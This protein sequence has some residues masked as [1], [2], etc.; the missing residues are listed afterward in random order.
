SK[1]TLEIKAQTETLKVTKRSNTFY[2]PRAYL[3]FRLRYENLFYGRVY[4]DISPRDWY[5]FDL[6]VGLTPTK[7]MEIRFGKFKQSLGYEVDLSAHKFP[8]VEASMI[9]GMRA[10]YGTRDFGIGLFHKAKLFDLNLNIVNGTGR[11]TPTDSNKWKDVSGRLVLKPI[12]NSFIGGNFY[13]GKRG[14][15]DDSLLSYTRLGLEV[16]YTQAPF[17][18]VFEYLMGSH[19]VFKG[20]EKKTEKPMGFYGIFGYLID[21]FTVNKVYTFQPIVRFDYRKKN[22]DAKEETGIT[23]GINYFVRGDYLKITPN[24]AYYTYYIGDKKLTEIRAILQ[25]QGYL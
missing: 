3:D 7:E 23:F 4:Y 17:T 22:K 19:E 14:A 15:K 11:T 20:N 8:F 5:S 21:I 16:G 13:Y 25:L 10:P 9:S 12:D 24:V 6:Y 2:I 1:E 18:L